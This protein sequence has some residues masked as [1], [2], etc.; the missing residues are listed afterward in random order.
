MHFRCGD[1][2]LAALLEYVPSE[3]HH[4]FENVHRLPLVKKGRLAPPLDCA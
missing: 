1:F 3:V 4:D 2:L